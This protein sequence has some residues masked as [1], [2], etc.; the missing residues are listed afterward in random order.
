MLLPARPPATPPTTA[1]TAVPIGPAAAVPLTAP[2]AIPPRTPAAA[3]PTAAPT[4]VPT[5]C[6]PGAPVI[7]SRLASVA[8][9]VFLSSAINISSLLDKFTNVRRRSNFTAVL[10]IATRSKPHF[11]RRAN[12]YEREHAQ[13]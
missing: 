7:G 1:P 4:P 5:G 10:V 8:R 11:C 6:A 2:A 3:P 13:R 12:N 9:F